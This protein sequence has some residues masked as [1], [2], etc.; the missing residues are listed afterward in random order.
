MGLAAV[1]AHSGVTRALEH[2]VAGGEIVP[3][4]RGWRGAARRATQAFLTTPCPS[5]A[6]G[7][8]STT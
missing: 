1:A 6:I 2:A 3:G 4:A 5:G 7:R 8:R